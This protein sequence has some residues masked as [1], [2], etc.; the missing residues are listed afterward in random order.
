M[1]ASEREPTSIK[2]LIP[3]DQPTPNS[4][5]TGGAASDPGRGQPSG[6]PPSAF[7]SAVAVSFTRALLMVLTLVSGVMSAAYFGAGVAKDCYLVAQT[8][9]S[10]LSTVLMSGVYGLVLVALS[11]IGPIEGIAGQL[12]LVRTTLRQLGFVLIPLCLVATLFP[13]LV[14]TLIAPGFGPDQQ[15]LSGHLLPLTMFAMV[16][17]VGF[18]VFRAL[19][20]ARHQFALPGFVNLLVGFTTLATLV[21]LV[22][23]AGIFAQALGQLLGTLLSLITLGAA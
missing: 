11:E 8:L 13:R 7:L 20:N 17:S 2:E 23:R 10:L 16:G 3:G 18:A 15:A 12:R 14:I 4:G 6:A 5:G 21:L 19:Y 9:P 1:T 22:G